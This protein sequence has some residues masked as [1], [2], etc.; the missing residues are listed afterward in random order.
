MKIRF[1]EI[2]IQNFYSYGP[3]QKVNLQQFK[4]KL[5][6][7][8]GIDKD[9]EGSKIGSGKSSFIAAITFALFGEV[10][11]NIKANEIVNYIKGKN[12]LVTI[13]FSV[14]NKIYK[15]ERGR[16]PNIL[17][18]F[19]QTDK[20][21]W[22]NI[23]KSDMRETD[24][25]IQDIIKINFE[26]FMQTTFFSVASENNKPFLHMTPTNQKKV[27]ENIFSFEVFNK[28]QQVIK[29]DLRDKQVQKAELASIIKEVK[30]SNEQIE[31]QIVRLTEKSKNFEIEKKNKLEK[32][33][34]QI[35][36]YKNLNIDKEREKLKILEELKT[37]KQNTN[38]KIYELKLELRDIKSKISNV[39][40]EMNYLLKE[41]NNIENEYNSL[42]K[43]ICP[44]CGQ[45]WIDEIYLN[46]LK[47]DMKNVG[48]QLIK[49]EDSLHE[50]DKTKNIIQE[51]I[52]EKKSFLEEIENA[53][54]K[55]TLK[56][57]KK[58][59]DN[60]EVILDNL[61]SEYKQVKEQKN[62]Y[63]DEIEAN[64][65]LIRNYDEKQLDAIDEW[66]T[67]VKLFLKLSE[68]QKIRGKFLR[69]FIKQLNEILRGFK[70]LIPDY[71]I[72]IQFNPDFTIRIM[73][74]GK[75][76]S[77]GSLSNGEKRIGNIMI[78]IALMKIFKIKNNVEFDTM[79]MDEVLDS[80]INGSL[81]TSVFKFI[82]NVAKEE[83]LRIFLISHREE[84]KEKAKEVIFVTKSRGISTIEI[85]N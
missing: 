42:S 1:K 24:K 54:D 80:G 32:I 85:I 78:M 72:H 50:F 5:V 64:K 61:N 51:T 83:N 74:L 25:L 40:Q 33:L 68:D 43:N 34:K 48:E 18:L 16:K 75:K 45:E 69:K 36:F 70:K 30:F 4:S 58:E 7:I 71:N 81:L 31:K 60:I 13:T 37:H 21:E 10:V 23:S 27:L 11:N 66:I 12:A 38:D 56:V 35:D 2:E 47:S 53:I 39:K 52:N 17:N 63:I 26:T 82:E 15:I 29:D 41:F 14:D 3:V 65:K 6:L 8:D 55:L 62:H 73:K 67:N 59:I 44:T 28:M 84:I 9:T 46:K 20:N 22:N 79:F 19:E 49:F 76:V 77:A 57:S